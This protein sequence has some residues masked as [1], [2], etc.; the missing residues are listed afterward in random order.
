MNFKDKNVLI[1]GGTSGIGKATLDL[2]L[3]QEARVFVASR[4][5]PEPHK[6][7]THI[8]LDVTEI[9]DEL[10]G[11][12][13]KLH[14]LVYTPGTITLKP[15]QSLKPEDFLN[16]LNLNVI[17][18]V[19]VIQASL[20]KL[21]AAQG[22]SIVLFST[23]AVQLGLNFHTAVA[24]AK[25]AV[26]GLARSLAAELASKNIRVNVIAPSLTDTPLAQNLLSTDEKKEASNQRHPLG[27][28]GRPD[29]IAQ[30]VV[31][32]LSENSSWVTGQTMHIDGGLST[33]KKM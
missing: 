16:E 24:T 25:G 7:I 17:G 3:D 9:S 19:K 13:D 20:G 21:K 18:A 28:Y 29:D 5:E 6:Q 33:L 4:K 14:G 22:S 2:L 26:E 15:F 27:R 32:L 23:V 31:Y 12:P 30:A 1:I 8:P 11:L 10:D